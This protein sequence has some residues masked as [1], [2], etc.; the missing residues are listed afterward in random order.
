MFGQKNN[1]EFLAR[2]YTDESCFSCY[3]KFSTRVNFV[4]AMAMRLNKHSKFYKNSSKLVSQKLPL[5]IIQ[6]KHIR[7]SDKQLLSKCR[8][9]ISNV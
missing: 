8:R 4:I 6:L 3:C 1:P 2:K 5:Y 9:K 7:I